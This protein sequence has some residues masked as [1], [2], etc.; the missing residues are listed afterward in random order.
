MLSENTPLL[1]N[2]DIER[3]PI[4]LIPFSE[5]EDNQL[6]IAPSG[7][8]YDKT[9]YL[10]WRKKKDTSPMTNEKEANDFFIIVTDIKK[11]LNL[12]PTFPLRSNFPFANHPDTFK[13]MSIPTKDRT[14]YIFAHQCL[15]A[16]FTAGTIAGVLATYFSTSDPDQG[17]LGYLFTAVFGLTPATVSFVRLGLEKKTASEEKEEVEKRLA[18]T[19]LSSFS[20]GFIQNIAQHTQG[21][22][23]EP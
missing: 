21:L 4:S 12:Q 7:H 17:Y 16:F 11:F 1:S 18:S 9:H 10:E 20:G 8:C 23:N 19:E 22:V 15:A 2:E 5:F 6:L 13:L 14:L 3:C